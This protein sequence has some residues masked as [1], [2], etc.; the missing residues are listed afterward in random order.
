MTLEEEKRWDWD[1]SFQE[2]ILDL[3]WRDDY[4]EG[5]DDDNNNTGNEDYC[6][7]RG[8]SASDDSN[9]SGG[10]NENEGGASARKESGVDA[11][12]YTSKSSSMDNE[13]LG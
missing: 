12:D 9:T 4:G 8:E 11:S 2:Q 3:D 6:G 7:K 1:K 13:D 5:M 10:S